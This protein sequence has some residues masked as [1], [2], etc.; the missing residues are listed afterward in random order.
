M[1]FDSAWSETVGRRDST[2][3]SK[4]VNGCWHRLGKGQAA[5]TGWYRVQLRAVCV[6]GRTGSCH[7]GF[8]ALGSA[9][10]HVACSCAS[11]KT[12]PR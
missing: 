9:M 5:Y 8:I 7:K 12:R 11:V 10:P 6:L 1:D 2:E 4:R 3:K